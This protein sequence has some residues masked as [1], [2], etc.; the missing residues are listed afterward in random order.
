MNLFV[1]EP[2]QL[3]RLKA[4]SPIDELDMFR[5]SSTPLM[6]PFLASDGA[7]KKLPPTS[8][9]VSCLHNLSNRNL[10]TQP[11]SVVNRTGSLS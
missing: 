5:V 1:I 10:F 8:L 11:F 3:D 6:S 7:L 4:H 2:E 9:L